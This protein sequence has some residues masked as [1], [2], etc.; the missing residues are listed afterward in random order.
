M[1]DV[2]VALEELHAQWWTLCV[3]VHH[4]MPC[5]VAQVAGDQAGE[6][7]LPVVVRD[8]AVAG[9]VPDEHRLLPEKT[10]EDRAEGVRPAPWPSPTTQY[11]AAANRQLNAAKSLK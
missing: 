10:Q 11:T 7:I 6:E 8:R 5:A 3:V 4:V 2:R 9:V 1:L